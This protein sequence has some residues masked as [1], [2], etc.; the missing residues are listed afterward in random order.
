MVHSFIHSFKNNVL[1]SGHWGYNGAY[2]RQ[3]SVSFCILVGEISYAQIY[4]N[5][6]K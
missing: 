4:Q 1:S 5:E 3:D 2:D 6:E